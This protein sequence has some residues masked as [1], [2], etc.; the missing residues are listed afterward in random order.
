M[1]RIQFLL[2]NLFPFIRFVRIATHNNG[3]KWR[4]VERVSAVVRGIWRRWRPRFVATA[5]MSMAAAPALNLQSNC[6]TLWCLMCAEILADVLSGKMRCINIITYSVR[7]GRAA[8]SMCHG[9]LRWKTRLCNL[10]HVNGLKANLFVLHEAQ[11][12]NFPR[13][14][15]W[16]FFF[17]LLIYSC[18]TNRASV[19]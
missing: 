13:R 8:R 19:T 4:Q 5:A 9:T 17:P 11:D 18:G 1:C 12:G 7:K 3:N 10:S 14:S 15:E 6:F 16:D 2:F